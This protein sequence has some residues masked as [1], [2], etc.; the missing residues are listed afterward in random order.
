M[1][2]F[3]WFILLWPIILAVTFLGLRY[4]SINNGRGFLSTSIGVGYLVLMAALLIGG[5]TWTLVEFIL[6]LIHVPKESIDARH[7]WWVPV[8]L[9]AVSTYFIAKK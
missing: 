4:K 9:P 3:L 1:G 7:G 8:L 2:A 5:P 6:E